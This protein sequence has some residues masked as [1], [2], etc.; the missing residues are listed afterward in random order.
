[1]LR[2][3]GSVIRLVTVPLSV[4]LGDP[5]RRGGSSRKEAERCQRRG[6]RARKEAGDAEGA[7]EVLRGAGPL[8]VRPK[9]LGG[10]RAR[11]RK[12]RRCS[13]G[14]GTLEAQPRDP[15]GKR[16]TPRKRRKCSRKPGD[17]G[18]ATQALE[19]SRLGERKCQEH[20]D[21]RGEAAAPEG[22][23]ARGAAEA[24]IGSWEMPGC[25]G[26]AERWRVILVAL[27]KGEGSW[28]TP[29]GETGRAVD[30]S[31]EHP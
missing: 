13:G 12:W 21:A 20:G 26:N 1:M 29:E 14:A 11:P 4:W 9:D 10:K 2:N 25:G 3:K 6:R 17:A 18:G 23:Q 30:A 31:D 16:A 19:R 22:K 8:E 28:V 7:A 15:G 5:G 27:R 24:P